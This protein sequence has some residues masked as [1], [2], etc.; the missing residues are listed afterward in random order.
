MA[1]ELVCFLTHFYE[2]SQGRR[3]EKLARE[4]TDNQRLILL[5]DA[6]S[7]ESVDQWRH[8]LS[9]RRMNID[10]EEFSADDVCKK[11]GIAT[12]SPFGLSN[13]SVHFPVLELASRHSEKYLWVIE[14]D[15]VFSGN[16]SKLFQ[17]Y[18]ASHSDLITTHLESSGSIKNSDWTRWIELKTPVV[19]AQQWRAFLP[20][21]R[22]SRQAAGAV[23]A[24]HQQGWVGH[25][26]TLIPTALLHKGYTLQDLNALGRTYRDGRQTPPF[27]KYLPSSFRFKPNI[28]RLEYWHSSDKN[29]LW[30]PMK[31]SFPTHGFSAFSGKWLHR[32]RSWARYL[33]NPFHSSRT[34]LDQ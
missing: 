2:E 6:T 24:C 9:E 33:Q 5:L 27:D 13:G 3:L 30:H 8:F 18:Q 21:Y 12:F 10:I 19:V 28:H 31:E 32:V 7:K 16:W 1:T 11:L 4:L 22:I 25:F 26:E 20:I 34:G 17:L 14:Y 29:I 23:L 15:V